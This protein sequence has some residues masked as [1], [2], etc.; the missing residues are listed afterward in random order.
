DRDAVRTKRRARREFEAVVEFPAFVGGVRFFQN[1]LP[2]SIG[3]A[4]RER[5]AREDRPPIFETVISPSDPELESHL[6]TRPVHQTIG[7]QVRFVLLLSVAAAVAVPSAI[8]SHMGEA[9]VVRL[10][11][12]EPV[13]ARWK[14]ALRRKG[15]A[16]R[17]GPRSESAS[18]DRGSSAFELPLL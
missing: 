10:C 9:T 4:N 11:G 17:I 1:G 16:V 14:L 7:D 2:A 5:F 13:I 8:E 12:H 3:D 18:E 6:L 15:K